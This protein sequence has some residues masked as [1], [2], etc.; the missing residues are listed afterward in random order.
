[1]KKPIN[2]RSIDLNLLVFFDAL[3][4]ER[5]VTRAANK[6]SISQSAMSNA[7]SRLRHVFK[8]DLFIR[9]SKGMEPT[10]RAFELGQSIGQILQQTSRLM[11]SDIHFDPLISNRSYSIRMSDL[12]AALV[13]PVL[14]NNL[15]SSAPNISLDILHIS[16]EKTV[17]LL[18]SDQLDIALSTDLEHNNSIR[19]Q[20]LISDRMVC[21]LRKGHP[22]SSGKLT[23]KKFLDGRHLRVS[24]SPTD[25]RFV[26]NV[27]ASQGHKRDVVLNVPHWLLI[28]EI[29]KKTDLI[30][31]I[32]E[33]LASNFT[34]EDLVL[35]P[36]PFM[37][38]YFHWTMYWHKR[39]EHSQ[40]H[41]WLR[42]LIVS[43]SLIYK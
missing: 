26:D 18:E 25:I 30:A 16:P 11:S 7:L 12:I 8:D 39:Y 3:M 40:S 6:V 27:L 35:R 22:L 2:L 9:T 24:M 41:Q 29:L 14:V 19:S 36:L 31:V 37:A 32:S 5:H 21:I 1:M 23:L 20:A 13:L 28:P 34:N 17:E 4:S 10:L 42:G 38:N 43:S 33:R 15:S